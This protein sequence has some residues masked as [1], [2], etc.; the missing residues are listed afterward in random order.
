MTWNL[1]QRVRQWLGA[2]ARG[3]GEETALTQVFRAHPA[4]A[5]PADFTARVLARLA[6]ELGW[7]RRRD[8]FAAHQGLRAAVAAG[9]ALV[10]ATLVFVPGL[11]RPLARRV[12]SGDLA[13]LGGLGDLIM[14][15]ANT[16][17]AGVRWLAG[18]LEVWRL[19]SAIGEALAS[20]AARPEGAAA[21]LGSA[22]LAVAAFR[23]LNSLIS[24][25]RSA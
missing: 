19:L 5:P 22:L 1:E 8:L 17:S 6:E 12:V 9:L 20:A 7:G 18:G 25:H 16:V 24:S 2:E 15:A 3:S 10:G 11:V 4:P 21:L 14:V 13:G 23:A